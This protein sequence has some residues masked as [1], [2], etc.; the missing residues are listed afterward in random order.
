MTRALRLPPAPRSLLDVGG[1]HGEFRRA[2]GARHPALRAT[3]LDL[4]GAGAVGRELVRDDP[5]RRI[6][7]HTLFQAVRP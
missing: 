2:L 4:G 1:A 5:V 6:P 7:A 3:V